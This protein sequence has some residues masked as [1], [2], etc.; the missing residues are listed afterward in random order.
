MNLTIKE[1]SFVYSR[2]PASANSSIK[3]KLTIYFRV[4]LKR[5]SQKTGDGTG[6]LIEDMPA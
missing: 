3:E 2:Y 5:C 4:V 6:N 1:E